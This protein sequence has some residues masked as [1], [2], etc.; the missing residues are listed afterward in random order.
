MFNLILMVGTLFPTTPSQLAGEWPGILGHDGSLTSSNPIEFLFPASPVQTLWKKNVGKG[1]SG[2][3]S[4]GGKVV[5]FHRIENQEVVEA[6]LIENGQKLW[7]NNWE[8]SYS[9]DYGKGDGPRATPLLVDDFVIVYSPD[10]VLRAL[11]L[12]SGVL[13]WKKNISGSVNAKR[14]FFGFGASPACIDGVLVLNAGG[15]NAGIVG[16]SPKDG[17]IIWRQTNHPPGY[18]TAIGCGDGNAAVFTRDGIAIVKAKT[19]DLT[20][21]KRWR[22]R[23][24]ASVNAASPLKW[25]QGLLFTASYG[26]GCISLRHHKGKWEEAWSSDEVLSSHFVTP[27][28]LNGLVV[29]FHG[30]QEQGTELRCI[31]PGSG[32]V[33]WKKDG[34]GGGWVGVVGEHVVLLREDGILS[35]FMPSRSGI[36]EL[37]SIQ[38]FK[39]PCWSPCAIA[40]GVLLARD[41]QELKAIRLGKIRANP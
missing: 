33:Y 14:P 41:G 18:A 8:T 24:E 6:Y 19:G 10:G 5:L 9:D 26:T 23:Q 17:D 15:I 7:S 35:V 36:Q 11:D 16:I 22:S 40:G 4:S 37:V 28:H 1:Y 25:S 20:F 34:V 29:G 13:K 12:K 30:R 38:V 31:D 2:P 39:G 32:K 21:E 27:V 3:V